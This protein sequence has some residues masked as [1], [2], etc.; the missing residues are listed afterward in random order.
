MRK[1]YRC[2]WCGQPLQH[3]VTIE[4]KGAMRYC[5]CRAT[6]DPLDGKHLAPLEVEAEAL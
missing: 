6:D 5:N 3:E 2:K 1:F 4:G